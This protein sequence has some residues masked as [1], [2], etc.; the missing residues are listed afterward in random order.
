MGRKNSLD[1]FYTKIEVVKECLRFV[2]LKFYKTI[3]EPSAGNGSFSNL[4]KGCIAYDIEPED[5]NIIKQ[6]FLSIDKKFEKPVLVIGNPPFGR[7][8]NMA[9]NF[10]RKSAEFA[11]TIAFILPKSFR[12]DS[13]KDRIPLNFLLYMEIDLPDNSFTLD[14][15][16]IEIPCVFQK[17]ERT[18]TPR[19]KSK[20]RIPKGF[21]FVKK[22]EEPDFSFRRVGV[23]TGNISPDIN[24][25]EQSHYFIKVENKKKFVEIINKIEWKL[26]GNNTVGPRSISKQE[27]IKE[28]NRKIK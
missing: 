19:E 18:Y 10:I 2:D 22:D 8:N 23:N 15:E 16:D 24:K 5:K 26:L 1:K 6:D 17:W 14:G 3:I 28:I 21:K 7:Q 12:K 11:D 20:K 9:I 27:M 13:L 25:S 4:I